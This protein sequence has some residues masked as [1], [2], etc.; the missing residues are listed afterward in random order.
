MGQK[1]VSLIVRYPHFEM[2]TRV[3]H[4]G[5]EVLFRE[6]SSVQE[7][8]HRE[9]GR[10]RFHCKCSCDGEC[11]MYAMQAGLQFGQKAQYV[12]VCQ[13]F[14]QVLNLCVYVMW[15]VRIKKSED[16]LLYIL[17]VCVC[18]HTLV[19]YYIYHS[20]LRQCE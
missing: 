6:V 10:E 5:W 20:Q 17:C 15:K 9:R 7:C 19:L 18:V 2:H 16:S 3:V 13:W 1:K 8:P 11:C 14:D 4:L 12:H